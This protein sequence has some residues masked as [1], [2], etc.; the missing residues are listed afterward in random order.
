MNETGQDRRQWGKNKLRGWWTVTV[1]A[2]P[3]SLHLIT[4]VSESLMCLLMVSMWMWKFWGLP[5]ISKVDT[6]VESQT[7]KLACYIRV[8]RIWSYMW[9][10]FSSCLKFWLPEKRK[11]YNVTTEFPDTWHGLHGGPAEYFMETTCCWQSNTNYEL[12]TIPPSAWSSFHFSWKKG[13]EFG[14]WQKRMYL[15]ISFVYF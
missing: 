2:H 14:R 5:T 3:Y 10:Q 15:F 12:Y 8:E 4:N 11:H 13:A 7:D 1:T 6:H 9:S